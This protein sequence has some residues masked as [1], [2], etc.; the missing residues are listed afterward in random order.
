V[1]RSSDL[2]VLALIEDIQED[3]IA[4]EEAVAA[5]SA[6]LEGPRTGGAR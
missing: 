1:A 4:V 2:A 5:I 6:A 3:R